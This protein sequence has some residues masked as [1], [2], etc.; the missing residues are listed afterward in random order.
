MNGR[1][2]SAQLL[3]TFVGR[4]HA[5]LVRP[6]QAVTYFRAALAPELGPPIADAQLGLTQALLAVG[7]REALSAA[8]A[9]GRGVRGGGCVR[10]VRDEARGHV[11]GGSPQARM[12]AGGGHRPRE[13]MRRRLRA[14]AAAV[15]EQHS[16]LV[17]AVSVR[18]P[19]ECAGLMATMT[20]VT[21]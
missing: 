9:A 19:A 14:G 10:L 4:Y 11:I 21:A 2:R 20:K 7:E 16:E 8:E 17:G 15:E 5:L 18:V 3:L 13:G 12:R 6:A 1:P